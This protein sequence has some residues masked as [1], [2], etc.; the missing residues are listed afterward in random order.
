MADKRD[1]YEVL[2]VGR[3]ATPE[4]IKKAYR[5]LARECHPDVNQHDCEAEERFKELNEAYEC[6]KD[7]DKRRMYDQFGHQGASGRSSNSGF[8]GFGNVGFGDIFN[9]FFGGGAPFGQAFHGRKRRGLALRP[10]D[11]T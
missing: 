5:R 1:Y 6:L 9:V 3:E 4:D 11:Y 7:T 10:R 8:G 2:G